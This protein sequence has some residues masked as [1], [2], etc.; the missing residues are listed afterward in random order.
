MT[1]QT[2]G[3]YR[4]E[5]VLGRG[6]MGTVYLARDQRIGRQV[7]LKMITYPGESDVEDTDAA[8][9]RRRFQ[10][11]A[12]VCGALQHRNIVTLLDTGYENERISYLV[13]EYI[14][15]ETLLAAIKRV[16]PD[17]LPLATAISIGEDVLRGLAFANAKGIIHRDIKPAN[18]LITPDGVAKIADFGIARPENSSLTIAGAVMGTPNYMSPEQVKALPVTVSADIF[19]TGVILF[20]MLTG[21]RPFMA[22]EMEGILQRIV[23]LDAP[24]V[25]AINAAVPVHVADLV[26]KMLSKTPADRPTADAALRALGNET[27]PV[28]PIPSHSPDP[29]AHIPWSKRLSRRAVA[30]GIGIPLLLAAIP[31]MTI[32]ARMPSRPRVHF[33]DSQIAELEAKRRTLQEAERLFENEAYSES[34]DLYE[35]HLQKYPHSEVA[36]AGRDRAKAALEEEQKPEPVRKRRKPKREL[37]P[38]ERLRKFINR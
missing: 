21:M 14:D 10:R 33:T 30:A 35:A 13:M 19:S 29:S 38:L 20:E 37:T 11:E 12:E 6:S 16:R 23:S 26:A 22:D 7:A 9:F 3:P 27:A 15:G 28:T 5:R 18:I 4:V 36:E 31:V 32:I 1:D 2:I 34:L 17:P 8:E 25:D 24:R